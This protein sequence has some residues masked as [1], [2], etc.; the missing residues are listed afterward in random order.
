MPP[1]SINSLAVKVK[2]KVLPAELWMADVGVT[3]FIPDP[4]TAKT[5]LK[6]NV[7]ASI[8]KAAKYSFIFWR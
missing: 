1:E 3:V 6:L 2:V 8:N 5:A 7:A 4:S